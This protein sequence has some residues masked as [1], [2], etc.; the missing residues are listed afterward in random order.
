MNELEQLICRLTNRQNCQLGVTIQSLWGGYGVIQRAQ[1]TSDPLTHVVLK[2]I[3]LSEARQNRRGWGNDLSHERKV[4]SYQ[5]ETHFY[6]HYADRCNNACRVPQLLAHHYE[7]GLDR[8]L[9]VFEDL[10][11]SGFEVRKG[12]ATKIDLKACLSWLA[13][14]HATFLQ[15]PP[16]GLWPIGTYWHFETR[17]DEWRVM[18]SGQLKEL[19]SRI[20]SRLNE[21]EFQTF[22]H[23]DAKIA[24]F[25][26]QPEG[27]LVAA[28]DF[29]Y[30]GGGCGIKDVVYFFS[31][32]LEENEIEREED[33]LLEYYFAKL[34]TALKGMVSQVE[35]RRL[36]T[37]WRLLY[38]IAWADF[39]RFLEGWAPDHWK[40]NQYVLQ[41]TKKAIQIL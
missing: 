26:F 15:T 32:C 22:V 6:R 35:F 23:G 37:E 17:P 40:M 10:D 2:H 30:V 11:A 25:C 33:W 38:P 12:R 39:V 1:L 16:E 34:E 13:H 4:K 19:A 5:V 29:Q 7:P 27:E 31:S 3:D 28:V 14:F 21:C 8:R 9:L 24:N 41:L 36:E 18:K 20:D